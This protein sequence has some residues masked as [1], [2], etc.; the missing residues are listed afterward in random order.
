VTSQSYTFVERTRC[1]MCLSA[2]DR[3]RQLGMRLNKSQGRAPRRV[4]G[5]AVGV[6]KC[7]ECDLIFS[8]PLPIPRNLEDHYALSP[9]TYWS[10]KYFKVGPGYFAKEIATAKRLLDFKPGMTA[11]DIGAG[12]GK[13]MKAL[14]SAGFAAFGLEPSPTFRAAAIEKM[15]IHPDR[16]L[17]T[18]V[19][20]AEFGP[21]FDF[22]TFGAVLEHLYHPAECIERVL[23]WLKPGGIIQIEVPSSSHLMAKILDTYYK[24]SGTT[25]VTH[26]SPM[27]PPFHLYEFGIK[28]FIEHG[29]RVG[30]KVA[31]HEFH[32]NKVLYVPIPRIFHRPLSWLMGK[33]KAGMQLT[34]W[35]AKEAALS[36]R[37]D[38]AGLTASGEDAGGIRAR[39]LE[40]P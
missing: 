10:P 15:G 1:E 28:S 14:E 6:M 24:L 27:H 3:H 33:R 34:V 38:Q 2:P 4:H 5:I 20:E 21:E 19:E 36:E 11:L 13:S 35:L 16:L 32:Q 26:L 22:I 9:E 8:D 7:E 17:G 39:E 23:K 25:Y 31:E 29:K 30:Y 12:M 18:A 37:D 40:G